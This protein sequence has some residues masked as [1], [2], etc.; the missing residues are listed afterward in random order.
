M[1]KSNNLKSN[2]FGLVAVMLMALTPLQAKA[3]TTLFE[4]NELQ[5]VI[6]PDGFPI[7]WMNA[8]K[9]G[10]DFAYDA[11]LVVSCG[12]PAGSVTCTAISIQNQ[13]SEPF[14]S[15]RIFT[16]DQYRTVTV[17]YDA[18]G[19][20]VGSSEVDN[21][22]PPPPG[23]NFANDCSI[24]SSMQSNVLG[25][26]IV[27]DTKITTSVSASGASQFS[28]PIVVPPA[29]SNMA[30]KL[31]IT[32]SSTKANGYMGQ[33]ASIS[34]LSNVSRCRATELLD[35]YKSNVN[36]DVNDRFCLD[37][38]RL[39]AVTGAY[40][41]DGT[42]Y[43]TEIDSFSRIYSRGQSGS[44]PASF[45]V[46]T[47][48]G[49][50]KYYGQTPDSAIEAN[51]RVEIK[52]WAVNK[53]I[54]ISDNYIEY[55]YAEAGNTASS[56]TVDNLQTGEYLP[57]RIDYTANDSQ[58]LLAFASVNFN[59]EENPDV[60]TVYVGDTLETRSKRISNIQ[61]YSEGSLVKSYRM[62]YKSNIANNKSQLTD[63]QECDGSTPELCKRPIHL[64]WD[65]GCSEP[66]AKHKTQLVTTDDWLSKYKSINGDFNGDGYTDLILVGTSNSYFCAGPEIST[67]NNCVSIST[68]NWKDNYKAHRGDFNS[69]GY[70]DIYLFGETNSKFCAGPGIATGDNCIQTISTSMKGVTAHTGDFN[71]DGYTD[72]YFVGY[73]YASMCAGP[74]IAEAP[75]TEDKCVTMQN[76]TGGAGGGGFDKIVF[77]D[78]NG[79]GY[80]DVMYPETEQIAYGSS[81]GL[82]AL[83]WSMNSNISHYYGTQSGDFN[84][85]GYDDFYILADDG[86]YFC[87]G[88]KLG[89]CT[90]TLDKFWQ[91]GVKGKYAPPALGID[92]EVLPAD[93]DGDGRTDL[94]I[95]GTT[96]HLYCDADVLI[97]G[98]ACKDV[99][100]NVASEIASVSDSGYPTGTDVLG[101][102]ECFQINS[103]NLDSTDI[104]FTFDFGSTNSI[105][106]RCF[107]LLESS[108]L[109]VTEAISYQQDLETIAQNIIISQIKVLS[110]DSGAFEVYEIPENESVAFEQPS[111]Q[112]GFPLAILNSEGLSTGD[113]EAIV[114]MQYYITP[115]N[116]FSRTSKIK[117]TGTVLPKQLGVA[118]KM[119]PGD[120]NGD[121]VIDLFM[122]GT[123]ASYFS[124]GPS[125]SKNITKITDSLGNTTEFTY[126]TL[127]DP[128]VYSRTV[129][130][131]PLNEL[132]VQFPKQVV[133]ELTV[134]NAIADVNNYKYTYSGA[135][136]NRN[137]GFLGFAQQ[138]LTDLQKNITTITDYNQS[139]PFI[140]QP[141]KKRITK[142]GGNN[143]SE[144]SYKY[145]QHGVNNVTSVY[146]Y[147]NEIE[148]KTYDLNTALLV[149][150]KTTIITPDLFG[151]QTNKSV[152]S[153]DNTNS[154]TFTTTAV[155]DYDYSASTNWAIKRLLNKSTV[156]KTGSNG[157]SP[158][159]VIDFEYD[160]G[161]P[162]IGRVTKETIAKGSVNELNKS[163]TYDGFGNVN[164]ET[165]SPLDTLTSDN[166]S[167]FQPRTTTTVYE[168]KGRFPF[169]ITNDLGHTE[170]HTYDTK[171]GVLKELDG[172]NTNDTT[173]WG[174]DTFGRQ[175]L[176]TRADN[177]QKSTERDWNT[178]AYVANMS[179]SLTHPGHQSLYS[180]TTREYQTD[181][182]TQFL[183]PITSYYD[184]KANEIRKESLGFDGTLVYVD[185]NY[186][187]FNRGVATSRPYFSTDITSQ[188]PTQIS[189][190]ELNRVT[191]SYSPAGVNTQTSYNGLSITNTVSFEGKVQTKKQV[192]NV[193]GQLVSVEDANLQT[194]NYTYQNTLTGRLEK[195]IDPLLN[196]IEIEFD[197]L[198]R[199]VRMKD[200]DMGEWTYGFNA[201]GEEIWVSSPK[202][203]IGAALYS[204]LNEYDSLGRLI[205]RTDYTEAGSVENVSSWVYDT[206]I[207]G[208]LTSTGSTQELSF[209]RSF[210]YDALGRV[211][212]I[213]SN[214]LFN[215]YVVD[216]GY[217][218]NDGRVKTIKYPTGFEVQ[219]SYNSSGY[220]NQVVDATNPT[221]VFWQGN[222]ATADGQ[223]SNSD[224]GNGINILRGFKPES[225]KINLINAATSSGTTLQFNQYG[226]DAIGNLS[227]RDD[228]INSLSET[229]TYDNLNRLQDTTLAGVGTTT[230]VYDDLGNITTKPG[231]GTYTYKTSSTSPHAVESITGAVNASYLYD[232][233]GNFIS[234]NGRGV[235]W[236]AFDKP[237]N[238]N[239]GSNNSYFA[240]DTERNRT[241]QNT[242]KGVTVY[243]N[244][245]TDAGAHYE[246]YIDNA[247][248]TEEHRH[249][250]Y[251]GDNMVAVHK[252]KTNVA[253]KTEYFLKDHLG[254][255]EV[256]TDEMGNVLERL[257]YSAFGSYRD[258]SNWQS[259]VTAITAQ[260]TTRGYTGHEQLD[261]IGL[262][263]MNGRIYDPEI[264]RFLSADPYIQD[265]TNLQS[266]NRY[267][268]V[269][270]N[271]LSF[272]DP[273]GY[274]ADYVNTDIDVNTNLFDVN[275]PTLDM[276]FGNFDIDLGYLDYGLSV[277]DLS[278]SYFDAVDV[279]F[280]FGGFGAVPDVSAYD[281]GGAASVN[282]YA[283]T[284]QSG[285]T[286][287]V[288]FIGGVDLAIV[289]A[290]DTVFSDSD[291][292]SALGL[293]GSIARFRSAGSLLRA[294]DDLFGPAGSGFGGSG[295]QLT[296]NACGMAC[297]QRILAG[298]G[299]NVFQSNLTRG[300]NRG[301]EPEVLAANLNRFQ[302]GW[303]GGYAYPTADQLTGLASNGSFIARLGGN[304]G[305]FVNV[306]SISN[307]VVRYWD[308][309]GAVVNTQSLSSFTNN[310][311][312]LVWR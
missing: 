33:G 292:T 155:N 206:L 59:Y 251:A 141:D 309:S 35:G 162:S 237:R 64:N 47:K 270:N 249:F 82:S 187:S 209:N 99:T 26:Y 300:F 236:T 274:V 134:S 233:N 145:L 36:F 227:S 11:G 153:V 83:A 305:H 214:I 9:Y 294:G 6:T 268:Y 261:D 68:Q 94:Y 120:Y 293:I 119:L 10:V 144:T 194:I 179:Q 259:P 170:T 205:K 74:G 66:V 102:Q 85:D 103:G 91:T 307:G 53:V 154:D 121:G 301:L 18:N 23:G 50:I 303:R 13:V 262:V 130:T 177:T 105:T 271:P 1:N 93:Y 142:L 46:E 135:K 174:F 166:I 43:R 283:S 276:D 234:G 210:T 29:T 255:T 224:Y 258:V 122:V 168:S 31:S 143:I 88:P 163:F 188:Y 148:A 200:P 20:I 253:N 191:N 108:T 295:G 254:S 27:G 133:S 25:D 45:E 95:V 2:I 106:A 70:A 49:N 69:D 286:S 61:T 212:T 65:E 246:K 308:P 117:L 19:K 150:T 199:K 60:R 40:G 302:T 38:Q 190:D 230:M 312:G 226:F 203:T 204:N 77:G 151:N 232:A 216:Y 89:G 218:I 297:G 299:I 140:G 87:P 183:S 272:T 197:A 92:H 110:N 42:E 78:F 100:P 58:A 71:G 101:N 263:H 284:L 109:P 311:S 208:K 52:K 111:Q 75:F 260:N 51:G 54:D 172:P 193:I 157:T 160:N 30:P 138:T 4:K 304:P 73:A 80:D 116:R 79:D 257:S 269:M 248:S 37:G 243:L 8:E 169:T 114:E 176:E 181:G 16:L 137:R 123:K 189:Y 235:T 223:F 185:A 84:G 278:F 132:D 219:N 107:R 178:T 39:I 55:F 131:D 72:M 281:Y 291:S 196:E 228:V 298:D 62:S 22:P 98:G 264:G 167:Y 207:I 287:S 195:T 28:V 290:F 231:V 256:V 225:G 34:G 81:S 182:L 32:Y 241:L 139:Y 112:K 265:P 97:N 239:K 164:T 310:V 56:C 24:D 146:P 215:N 156:T 275:I 76:I 247:S 125:N 201:L 57:C 96:K 242:S 44:G 229:F 158:A 5:I 277:T 113:Y 184:A 12:S 266:F 67:T 285:A 173:H 48:S 41:A 282:A 118:Y 3:V 149:S 7:I 17:Y 288:D 128:G 192:K 222:T 217:D 21:T 161:T 240:Y 221:T 147:L 245:N 104:D 127:A 306:E 129:T 90:K 220:L 198:G 180:V 280:G 15:Y 250:I 238:I 267:S 186:D 159:V 273:T 213:S 202:H 86:G 165:L 279:N 63:I 152:V 211:D 175:T 115:H 244:P 126:K 124:E 171:F 296:P 136:I 252:T 289:L 14:A